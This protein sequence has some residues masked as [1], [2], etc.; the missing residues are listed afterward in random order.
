M[1]WTDDR[2]LEALVGELEQ[3]ATVP[4]SKGKRNPKP[5]ERVLGDIIALTNAD[6]RAL[7]EPNRMAG[8]EL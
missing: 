2:Q 5:I 8:L 1:N 4:V 3:L 7:T 6:A